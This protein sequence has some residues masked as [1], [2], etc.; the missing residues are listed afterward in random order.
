[1]WKEII[2]PLCPPGNGRLG[3]RVNFLDVNCENI[4]LSALYSSDGN[5]FA[6]FY[7]C[8]GK[9]TNTNILIHKKSSGITEVDLDG[10]KTGDIKGMVKILPYQIKT[11]MIN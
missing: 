6:R 5:I 2:G 8:E 10:N 7:E 3:N 4:I 1:M 9:E 11:Y